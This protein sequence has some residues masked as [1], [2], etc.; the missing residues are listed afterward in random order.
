M[1]EPDVEG[2]REYARLGVFVDPDGLNID[3]QGVLS[4]DEIT[5]ARKMVTKL[6][7][8]GHASR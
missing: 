4:W 2:S 3:G 7:K 8:Y 5:M 6:P 1:I